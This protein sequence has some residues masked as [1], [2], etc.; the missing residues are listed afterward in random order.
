MNLIIGLFFAWA[1]LMVLFFK[2]DVA[3]WFGHQ[4]LKNWLRFH[5]IAGGT[6]T[7][8]N[9]SPDVLGNVISNSYSGNDAI[10]MKTGAGF[11]TKAGIAALTLAAPIAG[12]D[13][14]KSIQLV[15]TTGFAH[16]VTTPAGAI[17]GTLH[18][19]TFGGTIGQR[20]SLHA[21]NGVWYTKDTGITLT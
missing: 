20:C 21:F 18:I 6:E 15:D 1:V 5:A 7:K 11:I 9:Q 16:T 10:T 3:N 19:A 4:R 14:G 12:V 2:R 13:D 17:N 8:T